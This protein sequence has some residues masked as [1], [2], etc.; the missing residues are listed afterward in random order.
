MLFRK[1]ITRSC[2]YCSYGT[3]LNANEVLCSKRGIVNIDKSCRK[4]TYD[5][6]RRIPPKNK[7]TDFS[8][9]DTEDFSL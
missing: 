5:P 9:Y 7:A 2:Q 3:H 4:F 1:K 6:C 8:K